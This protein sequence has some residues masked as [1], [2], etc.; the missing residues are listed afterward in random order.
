M[1]LDWF[2]QLEAWPITLALVLAMALAALGGYR[3]G[4]R[5]QASSGDMGRGHFTAVQGSLIGLLALLLGFTF[6]MSTARYEMRRQLVMDDANALTG[7]YLKS[8]LLPESRR[9]EFQALLW[10]YVEVRTGLASAGRQPTMDELAGCL[11]R[12]EDLHRQLWN[13]AR[14]MAR[15]EPPVRGA[16]GLL[17]ALVDA[18]AVQR[19]RVYAFQ[20]R[21]PSPIMALLIWAA[22]TAAGAVGFSGGLGKYHGKPACIL[23]TLLVG[24][25]IYVILDLDRPQS[26]LIRV[27][28]TPLLQVQEMLAR[29]ANQTR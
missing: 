18:L 6:S 3:T 22:I 10:Q 25:T 24:G 27:D 5:L 8:S 16:D 26:G 23:L 13:S 28:Q 7:L 4:R 9:P 15:C 21:V 11:A 12:A 2:S 19:R 20:S 14:E 1:H 17:S 29:E